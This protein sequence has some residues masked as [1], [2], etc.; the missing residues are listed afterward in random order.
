M[1]S[2]PGQRLP[3]GR[4]RLTRK[5]FD[6][7]REMSRHWDGPTR[8]LVEP[9]SQVSDNLD[10]LAVATDDVPIAAITTMVAVLAAFITAAPR[11]AAPAERS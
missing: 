10:N 2:F 9:W 5:L 6:G 1:P 8:L 7:A 3:D 4:V 11:G